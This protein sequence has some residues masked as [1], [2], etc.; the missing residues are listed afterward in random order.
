MIKDFGL[1]IFKHVNKTLNY[2]TDLK[3]SE[4]NKNL[5]FNNIINICFSVIMKILLHKD[6]IHSSVTK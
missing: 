3:E 1:I 2:L 6:S 5:T 4:L